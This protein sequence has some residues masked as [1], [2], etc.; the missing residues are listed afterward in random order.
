VT[1]K[2]QPPEPTNPG[3]IDSTIQALRALQNH[4]EISRGLHVAETRHDAF[5]PADAGPPGAGGAQTS[6]PAANLNNMHTSHPRSPTAE[7][8]R[9]PTR[10]ASG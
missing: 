2:R 5:A 8:P 9:I 7:A 4:L 10:Y 3:T 1:A 6:R